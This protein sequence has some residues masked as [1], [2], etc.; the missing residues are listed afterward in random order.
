RGGALQDR[1]ERGNAG[2]GGAM[3]WRR[4]SGT[5][6]AIVGAALVLGVLVLALPFVP[7]LRRYAR[8]K[9]M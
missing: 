1:A 5:R 4:R 3:S 8:M 7:S 2:G 6:D 9:R